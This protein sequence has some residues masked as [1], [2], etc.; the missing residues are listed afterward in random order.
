MLPQAIRPPS[1]RLLQRSYCV[2]QDPARGDYIPNSE[3]IFS[4]EVVPDES[5]ENLRVY[6]LFVLKSDFPEYVAMN[7]PKGRIVLH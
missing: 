6:R 7:Y 2:T 4:Y 3:H 5:K 1:E